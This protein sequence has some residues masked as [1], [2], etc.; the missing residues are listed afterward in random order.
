MVQDKEV[1]KGIADKTISSLGTVGRAFVLNDTQKKKIR[2]IDKKSKEVLSFAVR[3]RNV[4]P[5]FLGITDTETK[6]TITPDN[7]SSLKDRLGESASML[8]RDIKETFGIKNILTGLLL[9]IPFLFS[10]DFKTKIRTFFL[11]MMNQL[12]FSNKKIATIAVALKYGAIALAGVFAFNKLLELVRVFKTIVKV[13][14]TLRLIFYLLAGASLLK[15]PGT[16]K[17]GGAPGI[18][19]KTE[20]TD[21]KN[22]PRAPTLGGY[23]PQAPTTAP[24]TETSRRQ[25]QAS[26][27][28]SV[29]NIPNSRQQ[30]RAAQ[31]EQGKVRKAENA[32][33]YLERTQPPK[34]NPSITETIKPNSITG[35]LSTLAATAGSKLLAIMNPL[36]IVAG[37]GLSAYDATER[38]KNNDITGAAISGT[39]A[40]LGAVGGIL[41]LTPAAP[42]GAALLG[43]STAASFINL[44]RD[45]VDLVNDK[46]KEVDPNV[47]GGNL[48][49]A[50]TIL[51]NSEQAGMAYY[52]EQT[53]AKAG[54]SVQVIVQE[55]NNNVYVP[56]STMGGG[57]IYYRKVRGR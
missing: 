37:V 49:N 22:P 38:Y 53:A 19:D 4:L 6:K 3:I 26:F 27:Q 32:R 52:I 55:N 23:T 11:G 17:P 28:K 31:V 9:A 30:K 16:T 14:D 44:G 12:G 47:K 45:V 36:A 15:K 56:V 42:I 5:S 35:K 21:N 33:I 46:P 2:N 20:K 24:T 1:I 57:A 29:T 48:E 13:A 10:E 8:N 18:P 54:A 51:L 39:A 25:A 34:V 43:L 50:S 7:V 40:T 41:L